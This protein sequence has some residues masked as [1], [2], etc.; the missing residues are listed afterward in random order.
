M[1]KIM[2]SLF[3]FKSEKKAD[4]GHLKQMSEG[5]RNVFLALNDFF[6]L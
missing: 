1:N 6:Y 2:R 4:E 5:L 3:V